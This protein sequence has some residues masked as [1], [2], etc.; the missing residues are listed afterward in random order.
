MQQSEKIHLKRNHRIYQNPLLVE[1]RFDNQIAQPYSWYLY[2][3]PTTEANLLILLAHA[4]AWPHTKHPQWV[5][6]R[7]EP[8]EKPTLGGVGHD[9]AWP[10]SSQNQ[11]LEDEVSLQFASQCL[12]WQ[13]CLQLR[14][15][16]NENM[17]LQNGLKGTC[18]ELKLLI[19][20]TFIWVK[21]QTWFNSNVNQVHGQWRMQHYCC[22]FY[23]AIQSWLYNYYRFYYVSSWYGNIQYIFLS[24]YIVAIL[25]D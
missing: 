1:K 7:N 24:W 25:F 13:M 5:Q 22:F 23:M 10:Q 11:H 9:L 6:F 3:S 16:G 18:F 2:L 15:L 12:N 14:D 8:Q 21:G 17:L 19:S 4:S 20:K